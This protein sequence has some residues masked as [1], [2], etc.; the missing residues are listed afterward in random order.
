MSDAD[1]CISVRFDEK[2]G[3]RYT[4]LV[5]GAFAGSPAFRGEGQFGGSGSEKG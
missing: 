3:R 2:E 1:Q 4:I 5:R